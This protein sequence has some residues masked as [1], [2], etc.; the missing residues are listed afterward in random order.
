LGFTLGLDGFLYVGGGI[1][2]SNSILNS[3]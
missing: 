3:C 2:N 1:N